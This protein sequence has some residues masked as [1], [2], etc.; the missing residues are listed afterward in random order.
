MSE[1]GYVAHFLKTFHPLGKEKEKK[2]KS[3]VPGSYTNVKRDFLP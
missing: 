2:V 1:R 3:G